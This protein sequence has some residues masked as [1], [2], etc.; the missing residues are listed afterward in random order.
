MSVTNLV[1]RGRRRRLVNGTVLTILAV[2]TAAWMVLT[3]AG[4]FWGVLVFALA[5][6]AGLM[7]VQ[8]RE[9]T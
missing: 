1:P 4:S 6:L 7:L 9:H 5:W 2:A 3:S 8:A